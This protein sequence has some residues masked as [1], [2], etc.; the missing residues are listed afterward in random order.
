MIAR[1]SNIM[2]KWIMETGY[3]RKK[4]LVLRAE[5]L[6]VSAFIFLKRATDGRQNFKVR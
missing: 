4:A 5:Q 6:N 3:I 2:V 1:E